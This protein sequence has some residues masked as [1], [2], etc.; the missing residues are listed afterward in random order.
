MKSSSAKILIIVGGCLV[1][2][3]MVFLYMSYQLLANAQKDTW[4]HG[5]SYTDFKFTPSL[6]EYYVPLCLL[7]GVVCIALGAYISWQE[8]QRQTI[9][10]ELLGLSIK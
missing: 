6:P 7:I 5:R 10:P 1:V 9:R 4:N 2:A 8:Y 3:P